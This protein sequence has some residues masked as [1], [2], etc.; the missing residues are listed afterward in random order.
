VGSLSLLLRKAGDTSSVKTR[1]ITLKDLAGNNE[2]A[3]G[4]GKTTTVVVFRA[5]SKQEY[6][7]PVEERNGT[8]ASAA[9]RVAR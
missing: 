4:A 5:S 7:V 1:T 2:V 3:D 8:S 6:S 9:R